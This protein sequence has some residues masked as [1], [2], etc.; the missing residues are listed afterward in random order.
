MLS[1]FIHGGGVMVSTGVPDMPLLF[2]AMGNTLGKRR[3]FA[4][5]RFC[6]FVTL[7]CLSIGHDEGMT[8]D[9][10]EISPSKAANDTVGKAQ[11]QLSAFGKVTQEVER[12]VSTQGWDQPVRLFAVADTTEMQ[13]YAPEM[14]AELTAE[15][16]EDFVAIEQDDLPSPDLEELLA[17][18]IWPDSVAGTIV[19][20]ERIVL[21]PD[22]AAAGASP[23]QAAAHPARADVRIAV[24]V[25]RAGEQICLLRQR[26]Y[27]DDD[28]VAM[29]TNLVPDL[30]AAL[31]HTL[32]D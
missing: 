12:F 7:T 15:Q 31:R 10:D 13:Q 9:H 32:A 23:E 8:N 30:V 22:A 11:V 28:Q 24:G 6:R 14:A 18:V 3:C 21:P 29:G 20:V 19:V 26:Q 1:F 4:A 2:W 27:D 16:T 17:Q 25:S 5:W